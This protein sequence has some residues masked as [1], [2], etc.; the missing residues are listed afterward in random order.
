MDP[1]WACCAQM[2]MPPQTL[3]FSQG[4]SLRAPRRQRWMGMRLLSLRDQ[5]FEHWNCWKVGKIERGQLRQHCQPILAEFEQ[6][7]RR[8]VELGHERGEQTPWSQTVR[9]GQQLLQRQQ[10]L[11]TF[12]D[13]VG[14]EP[15]SNSAE[16]ALSAKSVTAFNPKLKCFVAQ[17]C[18]QSAPA[19]GN[20][21][22]MRGSSWSK[23]GWP[24]A[25]EGRCLPCCPTHDQSPSS[26]HRQ[27]FE[28][29]VT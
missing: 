15:T 6:K 24:I 16:R 5:L 12:L 21:A 23:P 11:W 28:F 25:K 22:E 1:W 8:V 14:V 4:F 2:L 10:A 27:L 29:D 26:R 17:A 7:L 20:R 9:T 19:S 18:S 13:H 3:T